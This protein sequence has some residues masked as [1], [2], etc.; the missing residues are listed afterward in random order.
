MRMVILTFMLFSC[1]SFAHSQDIGLD[2]VGGAAILKRAVADGH[3]KIAHGTSV[4]V[5]QV[6]AMLDETN[7]YLS[8][9]SEL[10]KNRSIPEAY[11]KSIAED[12]A[13]LKNIRK[14]GI[15]GPPQVSQIEAVNADLRVKADHAELAP[16]T[17]FDAIEIIV[18]TKKNGQELGNYEIWYVKEAYRDDASSIKPSIVLVVRLHA[19]YLQ[20]SI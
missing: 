1:S 8:V 19:R 7:G 4:R 20:A 3:V 14:L 17:A 5:P 15:I 16:A 12:A 2:I 18:H 13:I 11:T 9:L 10:S 6:N